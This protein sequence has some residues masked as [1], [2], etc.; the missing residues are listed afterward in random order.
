MTSSRHAQGTDETTD[1]PVSDYDGL[2][3]G[4]IENRIRALDE[5][6]LRTLL[7]YERGHG[8]RTPVLEILTARLHQLSAGAEPTG[9]GAAAGQPRPGPRPGGSPVSPKTSPEPISPPPHGTPDQF[10]KAKGNRPR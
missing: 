2:S 4:E 10:G 5:A 3:L 9:G 1:L 7:E 6:E 8:K